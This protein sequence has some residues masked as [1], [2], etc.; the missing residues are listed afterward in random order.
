[1][2]ITSVEVKLF[3]I[4]TDIAEALKNLGINSI[5]VRVWTFG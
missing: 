2:N 4:K 1:M 3:A 5:I